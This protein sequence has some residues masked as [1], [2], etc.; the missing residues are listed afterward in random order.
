MFRRAFKT[1]FLSLAFALRL[2]GSVAGADEA[3]LR[4]DAQKVFKEKVGPFVNKYCTRCHGSRAKAGINLQ[5][6]LKNPGGESASLHWKKA[7]A[8][9][10][11]HDMPP[12]D[13]SKKPTDRKANGSARKFVLK[14]RRNISNSLPTPRSKCR[15]Y[16]RNASPRCRACAAW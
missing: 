7:V 16:R 3:A 9:V 13:S 2:V 5:S 6:A 12:E 15:C 11:V 1:N 14:A 10:K 4:A 8:N